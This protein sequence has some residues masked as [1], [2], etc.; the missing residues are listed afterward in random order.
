[1]RSTLLLAAI[2]LTACV[3]S[4]NL[5]GDLV[6][7]RATG[8]C[9]CPDGTT[10]GEDVWTCV[11]PDGG[12]I[13]GPNADGGA[14]AVVDSSTEDVGCR[15]HRDEDGDGYGDPDAVVSEC[16]PPEGYVTNAQDCDDSRANV[17]PAATESCNGLDDDCDGEVDETFECPRGSTDTPCTTSCGSTGFAQCS[18]SCTIESCA[19]P[20][21]SCSYVDD[22][23]DGKVD[24]GLQS[25]VPSR[26]YGS[27]TEALRTW[28]FGGETPVVFT[29][30]SG[31]LW[32]AQRFTTDGEPYG[33]EVEVESTAPAAGPLLTDIAGVGNDGYALLA[34]NAANTALEV[35]RLGP[36]LRSVGVVEVV[37]F[38]EDLVFGQ[39]A[40]TATSTHIL[41]AYLVSERATT[42]NRELRSQSMTSELVAQ[43][44]RSLA[45]GVN[46]LLGVSAAAQ[47]DSFDA[48]V[49]YVDRPSLSG[50][51]SVR[52]QKVRI[53]NGNSAGTPVTVAGGGLPTMALADD[54]TIGLLFG[55]GTGTEAR[56][57]FQVRDGVDGSL[58]S[59]RALP[60]VWSFCAGDL[61]IPLCRP[62]SIVWSGSRWLVSRVRLPA[63]GDTETALQVF[64]RD[65]SPEGEVLTLARSAN[66]VIRMS[67]GARLPSG[68]TLL[69][70]PTAGRPRYALFGC[71]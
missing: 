52:L 38:D 18:T 21:E 4:S 71:P 6:E 66:Q 45:W 64:D 2:S 70:I 43:P 44:P 8:S 51:D 55:Q 1:M 63:E 67:S 7:D 57:D 28:T 50:L 13:R 48:W 11:L 22:D 27:T 69:T 59:T 68:R 16:S 31:G 24:E 49:S 10:P 40:L 26:E 12:V 37:A 20:V 61:G 65:G 47:A 17:N 34:P 19:P 53:N 39:A 23:C 5:C 54:G 62:S 25:L 36:D 14:D 15:S 58:R 41:V 30:Y 46:P 29:L 35:R 42:N 33:A 9:R 32:L 56:L 3:D 60:D